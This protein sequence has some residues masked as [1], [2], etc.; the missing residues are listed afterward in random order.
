MFADLLANLPRQQDDLKARAAAENDSA[1]K[2][3][4]EQQLAG[5][6]RF[7]QQ[8][9][10]T[11]PTPPNLTMTD[12]V[13][14]FRGEREIRLLHFGRGHTAGDVVVYLPKERV[15]CTGDLLVNQV[16][17]LVDGF[18]D[19]W[20][21]ALDRLRALDFVDVIP[22]HGEPFKGKDRIDW[23]QAYL[24]D[25]WQQALKLHAAGIPADEAARRI[26]MTSHTPHYASINGPGVPAASVS[27][28]Y[29]VIEHRA[30]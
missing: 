24:R 20:P 6:Q 1:A 8:I 3:R 4:L 9:R 17:N 22:G 21:A 27:R 2:A 25:F 11:T 7:S 5:Q 30:D 19:E 18:V 29:A 28:V 14:L 10:E 23:F 12:R 13:T 15:V 16:A 26:D